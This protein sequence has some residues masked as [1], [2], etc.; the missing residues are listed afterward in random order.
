MSRRPNRILLWLA[1]ALAVGEFLSAV[2]IAVE[3]YPDAQP[4]F[5]VVFGLL[6]L[7]GAWLL[8]SG[9]VSA[10]AVVV[11]VL[12]LFEVATFP[13]WQRFT[14]LDWVFQVVDVCISLAGLAVAVW[15]F[16]AG[17]RTAVVA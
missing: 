13:T 2:V 10:G 11:G 4:V 3:S 7:V 17:R 9:R 1:T 8:R 14:V 16:L 15:A 12:C 6:F 5:A